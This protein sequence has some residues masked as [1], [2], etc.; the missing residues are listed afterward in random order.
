MTEKYI[1]GFVTKNPVYPAATQANGVWKLEESMQAV[2]NNSWPVPFDVPPPTFSINFEKIKK[3]DSRLLMIRNARATYYT[4]QGLLATADLNEARFDHDPITGTPLG[5][6]IEESRTNLLQRSEEPSNTYWTKINLVVEGPLEISPDGTANAE[7]VVEN[8]NLAQHFISRSLTVNMTSALYSFSVFIKSYNDKNIKLLIDGGNGNNFSVIFSGNS[9]GPFRD[10]ANGTAYLESYTFKS[11]PNN[12]Y[13]L[14][15]TGRTG[16]SGAHNIQI[17]FL[18][19]ENDTYEGNSEHK[20]SLWGIQFEQGEF[21]TSYIK[22]INSTVLRAADVLTIDDNAFLPLYNP[23]GITFRFDGSSIQSYGSRTTTIGPVFYLDPDNFLRLSSTGKISTNELQLSGRLE[24]DSVT[25]V[26]S[27]QDLTEAPA[28]Q[29]YTYSVSLKR[30][31][32]PTLHLNGKLITVNEIGNSGAFLEQ[33]IPLV[34]FGH[35]N[36]TIDNNETVQNG[37]LL[38]FSF[39]NT[40]IEDPRVLKKISTIR[41]ETDEVLQFDFDKATSLDYRFTFSRNSPAS[42]FDS[43]KILK[44]AEPDQA[45]FDHDPITG[46]NL[47]FLI[48]ESRKNYLLYSEDFEDAYW[49]KTGSSIDE[50][51]TNSPDGNENADSLIENSDNSE[52]FVQ[53][54]ITNLA[55]DQMLSLSIFAKKGSRNFLRLEIR[56]LG[57]LSSGIVA[58]Y[59]LDN[60]AIGTVQ[61][62]GDGT[63]ATASI[64]PLDNGWYRCS[65]V[66]K[67]DDSGSDTLIKIAVQSSNDQISYTGNSTGNVYIWGAQIEEGEFST[68]YIRN[69]DEK[70]TR[71]YDLA[72]LIDVPAVLGD[73]SEVVVPA[74]NDFSSW[75][76]R[77][78]GSILWKGDLIGIKQNGKQN[79]YVLNNDTANNNYMLSIVDDGLIGNHS[80]KNQGVEFFN[81]DSPSPK[82]PANRKQSYKSVF[83]YQQNEF[84][85]ATRKEDIQSVSSIDSSGNTSLTQISIGSTY[86]DGVSSD[87]LNGHVAKFYYYNER[88]PDWNL[89]YLLKKI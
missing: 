35:F 40:A 49:T 54:S 87:F 51:S 84:V 22:T 8:D 82:I 14:E 50:D 10:E 71:T 88:L 83:S 55:P 15:M 46:E 74:K 75:F 19:E 37:Y 47:G 21:V 29:Y 31:Q 25:R 45:R 41:Y 65:L 7:L 53:G 57:N 81:I 72:R 76:N 16:V 67:P 60:G 66:G 13:R 48:E 2:K 30:N 28:F 68:S 62:Q 23:D 73:E 33:G 11:L 52:H 77:D 27:Q 61:N 56:N 78:Q 1:G 80:G 6:L 89:E 32:Y 86:I 58:Y 9:G 3:L 36:A 34:Y 70:N 17:M 63:L 4:E 5:L 85:F 39:W 44:F 43:D 18:D 64:D 20:I 42:Y 12:W 24:N 69:Y 38:N 26:F 79:S 59:D